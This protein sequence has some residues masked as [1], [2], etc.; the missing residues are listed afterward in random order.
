MFGLEEV[1]IRVCLEPHM[2]T[3][4]LCTFWDPKWLTYLSY[5][6]IWETKMCTVTLYPYVVP[7]IA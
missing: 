2:S 4:Y 3:R 5:K 7:K 1:V 6:A